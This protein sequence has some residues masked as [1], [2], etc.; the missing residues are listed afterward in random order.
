LDLVEL[1]PPWF[2]FRD[3]YFNEHP[4]VLAG[5]VTKE[6]LK[7]LAR[8]KASDNNRPDEFSILSQ[9][10]IAYMAARL[11]GQ[12]SRNVNVPAS[13]SSNATTTITTTTTSDHPS[14]QKCV[15]AIQ[16]STKN[17]CHTPAGLSRTANTLYRE[18]A[19][20]IDQLWTGSLY[21][22]LRNYIIR[23]LLKLW[24][25]PQKEQRFRDL[26][27]KLA[28][29]KAI[30]IKEQSELKAAGPRWTMKAWRRKS[31]DLFE[32]LMD[33]LNRLDAGKCHE[34]RVVA[35][36]GLIDKHEQHRPSGCKSVNQSMG[37]S[38]S[39]F[40]DDED[41]ED[42]DTDDDDKG[43]SI[44]NAQASHRSDGSSTTLMANK[45]SRQ[46]NDSF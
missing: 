5:V 28:Q 24:L 9:G 11:F 37:L 39:R 3:S 30:A 26:K 43:I 45:I 38:W 20:A 1:F 33:A 8:Y 7:D 40:R 31:S 41:S 18:Y 46:G 35:V 44:D 19:T 13:S 10:F 29:D 6:L 21:T 22:R 42:S 23:C 15:A 4:R 32:Q 14:W 25:R 34:S 36:L 2:N 27:S 16:H 12:G 17:S